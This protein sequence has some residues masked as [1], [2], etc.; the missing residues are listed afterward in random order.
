LV[1]RS[2]QTHKQAAEDALEQLNM[3]GANVLGVV[4]NDTDGGGRYGY[5]Y[6]YYY[7]YY[8]EDGGS[9]RKKKRKM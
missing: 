5:R 4:V 6:N 2:D 3:V 7:K 8:G 9:S 1:L